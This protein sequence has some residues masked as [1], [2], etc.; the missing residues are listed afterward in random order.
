MA[1]SL[2]IADDHEVVRSGLRS[3]LNGT[4]IDIV[5]EASTGESAV[6]MVMEHSPTVVLLDIRM[7]EGDGLNALGRI[8]LERPDAC[9]CSFS[10]R[11][12]TRRTSLGPWLWGRPGYIL[13]GTS[14]ENL[15]R[16]IHTAPPRGQ[17]S[18]SRE[19]AATRD[20]GPGDSRGWQ[21]TSKCR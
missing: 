13:K 21:P 5:A 20:R 7:P 8:K 1:I 11:T 10:Q 4:D 17:T 6:R 19:A 16:A 2:L 14:R 12:T 9:R 15:V 3:L 18:W